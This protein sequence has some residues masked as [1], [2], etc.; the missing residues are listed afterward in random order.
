VP[1]GAQLRHLH[2]EVVDRLHATRALL[3]A[4]DEAA[5]RAAVV[6]PAP[7][8]ELHRTSVHDGTRFRA[9]SLRLGAYLVLGQDY[10]LLDAAHGPRLAQLAPGEPAWTMALK[11]IDWGLLVV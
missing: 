5:L 6:R 2:R 7:W 9:V 3:A 11:L 4:G 10:A 1:L 8:L